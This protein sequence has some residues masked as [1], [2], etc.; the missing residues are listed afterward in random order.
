MRRWLVILAVA[1]LVVWLVHPYV[2]TAMGEFLIRAEAPVKADAIMVLAGDSDGNRIL[3]AGEIA[4]ASYAPIVFVSGPRP[5]YGVSEAELAINFAVRHGQPAALFQQVN[6]PEANSTEEEA[7]LATPILRAHGIRKLMV[8]TSNYHTGRAGRI[9]RRVAKGIEI[10]MIAAKDTFY[11]ADGWW[12]D[13]NGR[14]VA[15]FEWV[16]TITGPLGA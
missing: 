10:H 8:V 3:K 1:A 4:M 6:I 13:R 11:S 9:W 5:T 16:K 14:K 15:F 2:L 7:A 12:K